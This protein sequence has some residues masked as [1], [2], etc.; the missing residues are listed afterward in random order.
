MHETKLHS[1]SKHGQECWP[2]NAQAA[3]VHSSFIHGLSRTGSDCW[4]VLRLPLQAPKALVDLCVR[5]LQQQSSP[6]TQHLVNKSSEL[7]LVQCADERVMAVLGS[8]LYAAVLQQL[9][10][11]ALPQHL[12]TTQ[13]KT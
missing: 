13:S 1:T 3:G 5:A 9:Q 4:A 10:Q 7:L 12:S 8:S 6:A 11:A 2:L